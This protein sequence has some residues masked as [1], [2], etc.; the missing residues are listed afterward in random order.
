M[1]PKQIARFAALVVSVGVLLASCPQQKAS[2]TAKGAAPAMMDMSGDQ[3]KEITLAE[4][5]KGKDAKKCPVSGDGIKSGEGKEVTLSTGKKIMVCCAGCRNAIE[6]QPE[7][8]AA[9][10]Y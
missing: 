3:V 7:K 9:L 5:G 10:M 2:S 8:Y 6:K 1:T 4:F